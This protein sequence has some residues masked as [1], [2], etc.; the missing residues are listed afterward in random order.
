MKIINVIVS[1]SECSIISINSFAIV[2]EQLSDDVVQEAEQLYVEKCVEL[3][4]GDKIN[5]TK[6]DLRER[7]FFREDVSESLEDG[8]YEIGEHTVSLVWSYCE[9]I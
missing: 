4:Y 3:K 5:E 2:E 8:Y 7:N 9:N 1:H 6:D